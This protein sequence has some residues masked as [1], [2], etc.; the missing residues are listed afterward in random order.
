MG[1]SKHISSQE[2]AA[3]SR[4]LA[5]RCRGNRKPEECSGCSQSD[6]KIS[7]W[8]FDKAYEWHERQDWCG[9]RNI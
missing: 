1:R 4:N 7:I 6:E 2:Y 9:C 3:M 5:Y 8:R